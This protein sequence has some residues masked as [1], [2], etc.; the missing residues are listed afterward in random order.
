LSSSGFRCSNCGAPLEISPETI[1]AIC[2]YCGYPNWVRGDLKSDIYI[3]KSVDEEEAVKIA[4]RYIGLS[5]I[6]RPLILFI[7]FYIAEASADADYEA[8]TRITVQRC[9][10]DSKGRTHCTSRSIRVHVDGVL[11]GYHNRYP[12]VARKGVRGKTI[13]TLSKY[14]LSSGIKTMKLSEMNID[15]SKSRAILM[16]D[17]SHDDTRDLVLDKHLDSLRKTVEDRIRSEARS[18]ALVHGTP[19]SVSILWKKITPRNIDIDISPPILVP[20]YIFT[21]EEN[22]YKVVLTGWDLKPLIIEKPVSLIYRALWLSLGVLTAGSMGGLVGLIIPF[23]TTPIPLA[24]AVM[25]IVFGGIVSW[26]SA[27]KALRPVRVIVKV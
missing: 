7:P 11:K 12:T 25:L 18:K 13:E 2:S 9:T 19:I 10:T 14:I 1:V 5:S 17:L 26:Y 24:I 23:A 20:L 4:K 27:K 8:L 22:R 15:R 6:N 21:D 3:V 16:I